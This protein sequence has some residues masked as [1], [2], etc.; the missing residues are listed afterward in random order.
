MLVTVTS[1]LVTHEH[2][3]HVRGLSRFCKASGCGVWANGETAM[4]LQE[5]GH[6]EGQVTV[7]SNGYPFEL[8]PLT[9]AAMS[10]RSR[11]S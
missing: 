8:G 2:V 3:D 6:A 9:V 11:A 10:V 7:F 5:K 4:Q 1:V